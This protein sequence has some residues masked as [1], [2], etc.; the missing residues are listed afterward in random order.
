M[1]EISKHNLTVGVLCALGCQTLFGFTFMLTRESA[2][3]ASPWAL[4]GWRFTTAFIAALVCVRTGLMKT[5][6]KGKSIK[7][8]IGIALL[9]PVLY[10]I[11]ETYGVYHTSASESAVFIACIPVGA[12]IAS[13]LILKKRPGA[14][15]L[16]GILITVAGVIITV[17]A[18]STSVSFSVIGYMFLT[19][20]VVAYSLYSVQVEKATEYSSSE[21]TF[22]MLALGALV[23]S[24]VA[25]I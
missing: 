2:D 3:V 21:L 5:N 25:V 13:S 7:P 17:F 10:F 9:Y 22:V 12:V 15:Q 18:V 8:L 23:Y 1:K 6:L 19:V 24:V 4:L 20:A 11:G 16:A 14:R